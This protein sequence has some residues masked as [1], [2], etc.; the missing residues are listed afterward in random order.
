MRIAVWN[1]QNELVASS[2]NGKLQVFR[3]MEKDI[4]GYELFKLF[5]DLIARGGGASYGGPLGQPTDIGGDLG[6]P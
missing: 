4:L 3:P 2:Q 5:V 6:P 1:A